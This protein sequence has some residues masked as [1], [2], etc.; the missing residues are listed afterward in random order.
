MSVF[1][2]SNVV[3]CSLLCQISSSIVEVVG[4]HTIMDLTE[5][6]DRT[7]PLHDN[8]KFAIVILYGYFSISV[9]LQVLHT[10]QYEW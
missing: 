7:T 2:L 1:R 4:R 3:H 8:I 10:I 9:M 5:H 6:L